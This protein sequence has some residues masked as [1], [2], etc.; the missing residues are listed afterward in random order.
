MVATVLWQCA[1]LALLVGLGLAA[2][3]GA[4][5][6]FAPRGAARL[7][8]GLSRTVDTNAW[9]RRLDASFNIEARIY[10]HHRIAGAAIC[11]GALYVLLAWPAM[12]RHEQAMGALIPAV[13]DPALGWLASAA[14]A[15]V[16]V[17]HA[18]VFLLGLVMIVRPSLLKPVERFGNR[19]ISAEPLGAA[20]DRSFDGPERRL[21]RRPRLAGLVILG[22]SLFCLLRLWPLWP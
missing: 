11:L 15:I 22:A 8:A 14:G 13:R 5:L 18:T 21:W 17:L 1:L 6:L 10:R 12:F 3:V 7:N 9:L 20:L 2:L 16:L 19:W 4:L